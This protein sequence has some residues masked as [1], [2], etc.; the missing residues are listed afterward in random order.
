MRQL[1]N[2]ELNQLHAMQHK[3]NNGKLQAAIYARKSAEDERQTSLPTQIRLCM[4][5]AEQYD[6]IE[7][8]TIYQEDNVSGMFT[9]G[10]SEFKRMMNAAKNG[11]L[12]IVIVAKLDR[13]ARDITD[14]TGTIKLLNAYGCYL[15]ARR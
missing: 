13:L 10:R 15:I 14:A 3:R 8:S 12:D 7:I 5:F 6:F 1:T 11:E 9:D 4:D 2:K